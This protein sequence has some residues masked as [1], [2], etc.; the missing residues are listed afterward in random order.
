MSRSDETVELEM[1]YLARTASA[2][3]FDDGEDSDALEVRLP[4]SQCEGE[5]RGG[6]TRGDI[7]KVT[8]PEWL[9]IER[10]LV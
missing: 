2:Y 3:L 9:A 4:Q 1:R 10:G 6:W 8:V 7:V 5:P